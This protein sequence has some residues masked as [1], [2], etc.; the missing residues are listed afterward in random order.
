MAKNI[1]LEEEVQI[2]NIRKVQRD[3]D[4]NSK[5]I[6]ESADR[7]VS[8]YCEDLDKYMNH[9]RLILSYKDNP[10]TDM[11]LEEFTLNLPVL[12]Y[13]T[14]EAQ[15]SLGIKEDISKAI[16]LEVYNI[17]YEQSKGTIADKTAIAEQAATN[18]I[19]THIIYQRAYKKIKLRMELGNETLQSVK[20]VV[21]RRI[22]EYGLSKVDAGRIGG[23]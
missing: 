13:F 9:I 18:E 11:E 14:G 22:A 21:S 16:Q 5:L 17:A 15:E 6:T 4:K 1:C 7:L 2:E 8:Q 20:K 12:L 19:I 23:R 3:V 10:P